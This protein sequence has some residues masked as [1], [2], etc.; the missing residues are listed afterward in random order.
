VLTASVSAWVPA[1]DP[2]AKDAETPAGKP[3]AESATSPENPPILV[4]M[5]VLV[6]LPPCAIDTVAGVADKE[7]LGGGA[8]TVRGVAVD[9]ETTPPH[10][11]AYM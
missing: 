8:T 2:S 7:K 10:V 6:P 4:T 9:P 5:M 3:E 11:T 1:A